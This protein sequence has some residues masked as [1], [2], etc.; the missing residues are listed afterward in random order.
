MQIG[1]TPQIRQVRTHVNLCVWSGLINGDE[2]VRTPRAGRS[3]G[4]H[5]LDVCTSTYQ[6]DWITTNLPNY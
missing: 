3:F 4:P 1:I 5:S 6:S 2:R